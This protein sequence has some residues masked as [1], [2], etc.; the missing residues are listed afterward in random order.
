MF[1]LKLEPV[2]VRLEVEDI[3]DT[4][5]VHDFPGFLQRENGQV[6]YVSNNELRVSAFDYHWKDNIYNV[7][8]Y[9]RIHLMHVESEQL[10]LDTLKALMDRLSAVSLYEYVLHYFDR[11]QDVDLEFERLFSGN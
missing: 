9:P 3:D 4:I 5:D 10:E 1:R 2:T 8:N 11:T 7:T 6:F